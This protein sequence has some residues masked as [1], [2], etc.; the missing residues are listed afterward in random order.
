MLVGVVNYGMGNLHSITRKLRT[1]GVDYKLID[2]P[3]DFKDVDKIILP[4][5]G[6][7]GKAMENLKS[8]NIIDTLNKAVLV[9][10]KPILGIC[11]GM[12]LMTRFSEEGGEAGLG[13]IDGVVKRF[14][15]KDILRYKVPHMGWNKVNVCKESA[16]FKDIPNDSEF[17]FVHSFY[18][19][20]LNPDDTLNKTD[21]ESV[22]VSAFEK[23]NIFGVQYHPEKSFESG[24]QLFKNFLKM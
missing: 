20:G 14:E 3:D 13:W 5:V 15:V 21:Y 12:Q 18:F 8:K 23:E 7:F 6:H 19:E 16:L 24:N 10:K 9:D 2:S 17:Y 1:I 22:F 4:G 11:L